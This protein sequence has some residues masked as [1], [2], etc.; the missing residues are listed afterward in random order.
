MGESK[1]DR[2]AVHGCV[3]TYQPRP[4][5]W[6]VQSRAGGSHRRGRS[7]NELVS[8]VSPVAG[9]RQT[10]TNVVV[11]D[12]F[13]SR[14]IALVVLTNVSNLVV[15]SHFISW[16]QL[17]YESR[18]DTWNR[19]HIVSTSS[20]HQSGASVANVLEI[21]RTSRAPRRSDL[22]RWQKRTLPSL[23]VA[24]RAKESD[25]TVSNLN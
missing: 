5:P 4:M 20:G 21:G 12:R 24:F 3:G 11:Q 6:K 17:L 18:R 2:K 13:L 8:S 14:C 22:A 23:L 7:S 19:G 9:D 15:A 10:R 16:S 25:R 1:A